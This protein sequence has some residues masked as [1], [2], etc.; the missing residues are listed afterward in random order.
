MT[1]IQIIFPTKGDILAS[2]SSKERV[3]RAAP[4]ASKSESGDAP[5]PGQLEKQ[6]RLLLGRHNH[7]FNLLEVAAHDFADI[8]GKQSSEAAYI[9][10]RA[11]KMGQH[12]V[13]PHATFASARNYLIYSHISYVF[14]AGDVIC[15]RIRATAR[16]KALKTESKSFFDE[17]NTGDFVRKTLALAVLGTLPPEQRDAETVNA[18][19]EQIRSLEPFA[20]VDYFRIVRNEELHSKGEAEQRVSEAR[21]ALPEAK[22]RV[23]YG[24]MPSSA[25]QLSAQDALLCSKA[26]QDV[27]RWLCRH[28]LNDAEAHALLKSTFGGRLHGERRA[29]A[30]G[31]F[32]QFELLYSKED[33]ANGLSAMGW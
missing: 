12:S 16:M 33:I 19:V 7:H 8:L 29:T 10:T 32:M 3:R 30:A 23:L 4:P 24:E 14:S 11:I 27:V 15:K 22:I 6:F 1:S 20:L 25:D 9:R 17:I 18:K 28:M 5:L 21:D 2:K 26:W 13:Y 31:K